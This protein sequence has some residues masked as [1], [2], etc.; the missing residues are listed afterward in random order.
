MAKYY[1][2]KTVFKNGTAYDRGAP[3][4][5][6]EDEFKSLSK[7]GHVGADTPKTD[8]K[9]VKVSEVKKNIVDEGKKDGSKGSNQ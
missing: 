1:V 4:E 7:T 5:L 3:I 8:K 9:A 6:T 2:H